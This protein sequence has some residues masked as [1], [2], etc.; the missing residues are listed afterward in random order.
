MKAAVVRAFNEPLRIEDRPG[1]APSQSRQRTGGVD[2]RLV[3][4][5]GE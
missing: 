4:D 2:A 5:F 1:P 3:F